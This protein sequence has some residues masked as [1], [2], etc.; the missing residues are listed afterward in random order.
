MAVN[1]S[2][3]GGVAGQFF[4]NNGD[5]LS[6]GKIFTYA[7]G[8]TTNQAT[9]TSAAGVTA[10]SNPIILDAAGRVPGGEI[11]LTDGL[12]YKFVIKTSTDVLIGTFDNIIGI[13]SNFVNFTTSD[14]VQI[15]T[16]G[17]T[18][19]TL[20]TMSY[21]PNTNNLVV[22]VDGV[23]QVE[24]GSYSYV[25]TNSTTVTFTAGLHLGAVVKFVSAEALSTNV[26]T[27]ADTVYVPAGTGAVTTTVQTKLR[28]TVSVKD[29]GAVGDGVTDD[30]A[31]IQLAIDTGSNVYFPFTSTGYLITDTLTVDTFSQTLFA[32]Q[33]AVANRP[34]I[35]LSAAATTMTMISVTAASVIF[36]GLNIVGRDRTVV[37]FY[38]I[39]CERPTGVADVD[40][41]IF[42][43]TISACNIAVKVVGR[44]LTTE[45]TNYVGNAFCF[46]LAWPSPFVAGANP[47]QTALSGMRV[48]R[49]QDC[50]FHAMSTGYIML[51]EGA[52]AANVH[53]IQF[54]GN[55]IDTL[56]AIFVGEL[57]DSVIS[58]NVVINCNN[59]TR[60]QI[61]VTGASDSIISNNLFYGMDDNGSGTTY[62]MIVGVSLT[63]ATRVQITNNQFNRINSDVIRIGT[64]CSNI[65]INGNIMKN[66]CL[67]NATS[68]TGRAPVRISDAISGLS[69]CDN[70][71]ET[72]NM[73][74][75]VAIVYTPASVAVTN[76]NIKGNIFD[77]TGWE[78]TNFD[79]AYVADR[80]ETDNSFIRYTGDGAATQTI[81]FP[82]KPY[83]AILCNM[84]AGAND[85]VMITSKSTAG[86]TFAD[87]DGY[88]VIVTGTFNTNLSQYSVYAF[89]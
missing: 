23:N 53:G 41:Y 56:A 28:E 30:T 42:D 27:A 11:W 17:Q 32:D 8:T 72:P 80:L 40:L 55:Y 51:N 13:N 43:C 62:E 24:G 16:A 35:T 79:D 20:T 71:I 36:K 89:S 19:F 25:E 82:F 7:A 9:Y 38:G 12:Q 83:V 88:T 86:S 37:G 84:T 78:L 21:Q 6:G 76:Y 70:I 63:N 1:L 73:T 46:E 64:G 31:A 14:E 48:Y 29:F 87:I 15:A 10:H 44:G 2:P 18:V 75:N 50:R 77:T 57:H 45:R 4:D 59:T 54:T 33:N 3:V 39:V 81:T 58:N 49:V 60:P 66:V 47:D 34:T 52:N 65:I 74:Y 22:Y 61:S 85:M 5:P 69:F 68:S 67:D 26:A